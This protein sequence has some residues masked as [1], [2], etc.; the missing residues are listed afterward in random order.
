MWPFVLQCPSSPFA[1]IFVSLL[2]GALIKWSRWWWPRGIF[3]FYSALFLVESILWTPR[4]EFCFPYCG[5]SHL[6][7]FGVLDSEANLFFTV[8]SLWWALSFGEVDLLDPEAC[9]FIFYSA[10]PFWWALSFDEVD[11][12]DPE[13]C[14]FIFYSAVSPLVG[15]LMR[16]SRCCGPRGS[17]AWQCSLSSGVDLVDPEAQIYFLQW[18]TLWHPDS[19]LFVVVGR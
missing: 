1:L 12:L 13:A 10:H 11:L 3:I 6:S 2:M 14:E 15:A 8:I 5:C 9:E 16:W 18:V 7:G 17:L 4:Y 19:G